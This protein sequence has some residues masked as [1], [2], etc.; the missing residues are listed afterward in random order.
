MP[1]TARAWAAVLLPVTAVAVLGACAS[2]DD[3]DDDGRSA[4]AASTTPAPSASATSAAPADGGT[5][6]RLDY[7]GSASGGFDV[8]TSVACATAGGKLVAVTAPAPDSGGSTTPSFV[9]TVGDQSLATLVTA[10]KKTFVKL[11][12]DGISAGR[13]GATWTVR[14]SGTELG[15]T[16]AS[17]GSV[18][19]NGSLTCTKVSGT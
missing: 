14:I 1:R 4:P 3:K 10:E 17:G 7:T 15:A 11:G 12:A 19:L 8:T 13:Q 9:A 5:H 2:K 6:G 18:T 16:D